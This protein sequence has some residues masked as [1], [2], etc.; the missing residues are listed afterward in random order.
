MSRYDFYTKLTINLESVSYL[1]TFFRNF[2][3]ITYYEDFN[4]NH[5]RRVVIQIQ[6]FN[7]GHTKNLPKYLSKVNEVA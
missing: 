6:T 7:F 5:L 3:N 4:H 2:I 1:F